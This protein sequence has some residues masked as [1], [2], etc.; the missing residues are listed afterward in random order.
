MPDYQI[1]AT[2]NLIIIGAVIYE[3]SVHTAISFY[4][5][6]SLGWLT[7]SAKHCK[8]RNLHFLG[9]LSGW[10]ISFQSQYHF[11]PFYA[12]CKKDPNSIVNTPNSI[13]Q[14]RLCCV[15]T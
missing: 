12:E 13:I 5:F 11:L 4:T 7:K 2:A 14:F 6:L 9:Q 8:K 1:F 15:A 3:I 10:L